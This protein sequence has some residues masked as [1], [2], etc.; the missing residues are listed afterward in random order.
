MTDEKSSIRLPDFISFSSPEISFEVDGGKEV[1]LVTGIAS[2]PFCEIYNQ[3][4]WNDRKLVDNHAR[5][6]GLNC[7]VPYNDKST[8]SYLM[9]GEWHEWHID[10]GEFLKRNRG[11][12]LEVR[13]GLSR[14]VIGFLKGR[15]VLV[16]TEMERLADEVIKYAG[17]LLDAQRNELHNLHPNDIVYGRLVQGDWADERVYYG[18]Q[19]ECF[20]HLS[21]IVICRDGG[22]RRLICH[23]ALKEVND[24][25][26]WGGPLGGNTCYVPIAASLFAS[27]PQRI[28][29]VVESIEGSTVHLFSEELGKY[30]FN[31][32][33]PAQAA[34]LFL[35]WLLTDPMLFV[36]MKNFRGEFCAH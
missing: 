35:R 29:F 34:A 6:L 17:S 26:P 11:R 15:N 2:E 23:E 27:I 32:D 14:S 5:E 7:H 30:I 16:S 8:P 31:T 22:Q 36:R 1:S 12:N 9:L 20:S 24:K 13:R 3:L 18:V 33:K 4:C 25:F 21:L 28:K 10:G 19:L